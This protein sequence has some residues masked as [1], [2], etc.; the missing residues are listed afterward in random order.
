MKKLDDRNAVKKKVGSIGP[1][2]DFFGDPMKNE[3]GK[4]I[5]VF[6][7][8]DYAKYRTDEWENQRHRLD[9]GD[10]YPQKR[11]KASYKNRFNRNKRS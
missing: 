5:S 8:G 7:E 6:D 11:F 4:V 10:K 1:K 9:V 3:D 2:K